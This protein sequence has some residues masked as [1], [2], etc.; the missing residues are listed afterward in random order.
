[1]EIV[2]PA[3][4]L[5]DLIE[6]PKFVK[7]NCKEVAADKALDQTIEF[8]MNGTGNCQHTNLLRCLQC[9]GHGACGKDGRHL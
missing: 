4:A 7:F 9:S 6:K 5:I 1:M 2:F 8:A 3:A